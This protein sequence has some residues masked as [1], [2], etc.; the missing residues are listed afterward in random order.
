MTITVPYN[1]LDKSALARSIEN[2]LLRRETLP[3]L[4]VEE[5]IGAGVYA[6]YYSG[7][8][9]AYAPLAGKNQGG[10]YRQP[11]YVGKAI[12][13][14][15][16]KGGLSLDAG[17]GNS[18]QSR[19]RKHSS[20][21]SDATNLDVSHFRF[22]YLVV[23]DIWIPLGENILIETFKPLWNLVVDGFGNND[24]GGR[25]ANQ[26]RS[27]WDTLHPGRHWAEKLAAGPITSNTI[28]QRISDYFSGAPMAP[29]AEESDDDAN[30]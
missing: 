29:L 23:E 10:E 25:R 6:I 27:S 9:P 12:P 30:D 20:S 15:G 5:I 2:E 18:L 11:I 14:G 21:I 19:L 28:M 22:R 26:F 7:D 13:K 1:P 4:D 24:P 17:A 3:L 16:R 8:F